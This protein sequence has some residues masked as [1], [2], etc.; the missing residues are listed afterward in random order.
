MKNEIEELINL[1]FTDRHTMSQTQVHELSAW[2]MAH[3]DHQTL[4]LERALF[5]RM[6]HDH[7][8]VKDIKLNRDLDPQNSPFDTSVFSSTYQDLLR[9]E[10]DAPCIMEDES[11]SP[12][13]PPAPRPVKPAGPKFWSS[14]AACAALVALLLFLTG[15][16]LS[17]RPKPVATVVDHYHARWS[18]ETATLATGDMLLDRQ[19]G[20]RHLESGFVKIEFEN[21][22]QCLLEGPLAFSVKGRKHLILNYGR[23]CTRVPSGLSGFRVSTPYRDILD[24]G[25]EFG[26]DVARNG[27][28][29]V[30]MYEGRAALVAPDTPLQ[31]T[32][33][34]I[35]Q[36][37][38][39]LIDTR[40][41]I[42]QT[43]MLPNSL[44]RQFSSSTAFVWR[45]EPIDLA[46]IVGGGDGFG[47]GNPGW[48]ID[49][50]DGAQLTTMKVL[51]PP[52]S[53]PTEFQTVPDN[54]YIDSVL[55]PNGQYGP[56]RISSRGHLAPDVPHTSGSRYLGIYFGGGQT[57]FT[58]LEQK[59]RLIG[60]PQS[61]HYEHTIDIQANQGI[62]FDLRAMRKRM[63]TMDA[64]LTLIEFTAR[65]GVPVNVLKMLA[66][67]ENQHLQDRLVID[68]WIL[69]DGKVRQRVTDMNPHRPPMELFVKLHPEDEFLT[70]LCLEGQDQDSSLDWLLLL[71]PFITV[72]YE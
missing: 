70:F 21:G 41:K 19:K 3:P 18:D 68:L 11:S 34:Q 13:S 40:G 9:M 59:R 10:E 45:G 51:S 5:H 38:A 15:L 29:V 43:D 63:Q 53:H 54:P 72:A 24:L 46:D 42:T 33:T 71:D 50:L 37:Q 26:L 65:I 35:T 16:I 8:L 39:C 22:T 55:I 27:S 6:L 67:E 49:I 56:V 62:T 60:L 52:Q 64:G 36:D 1:Y 30:Q 32:D 28:A 61:Q 66:Q 47:S 44:V 2:I 17:R 7:L 14:I 25:T 58:D 48:G 57:F 69:V 23:L 12:P 4:F 31:Q 20:S